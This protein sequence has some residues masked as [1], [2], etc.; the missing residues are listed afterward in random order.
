MDGRRSK[1]D[2]A[3]SRPDL[4]ACTLRLGSRSYVLLSFEPREGKATLGLT[5][6]ETQ[7]AR[8]LLAGLSNAEIGRLRGCS[9]RTVAN[10]IACIYSKLGVHSRSE[11]AA[12]WAAALS[13]AGR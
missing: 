9:P 1:R 11:L 3:V 4:R 6:A 13:P 10:Q 2:S 7:V 8:A 5:P 12:R